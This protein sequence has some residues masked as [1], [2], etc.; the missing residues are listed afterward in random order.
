[1]NTKDFVCN[2]LQGLLTK[3]YNH[4][5]IEA[6]KETYPDVLPWLFRVKQQGIWQNASREF[7]LDTIDYLL[8]KTGKE[9]RELSLKDYNDNNLRAFLVGVFCDTPRKVVEFYNKNKV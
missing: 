3:H 9:I 2:N 5:F 8:S 1:L 6:V 7:I 4:S